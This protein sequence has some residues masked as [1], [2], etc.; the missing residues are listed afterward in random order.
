[1]LTQPAGHRRRLILQRLILPSEILPCYEDGLRGYVVL[2]ALAA[3][4]CEAHEPAALRDESSTAKTQ[5]S[6]TS[7][8][9]LHQ[10][11]R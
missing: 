2:E 5:N 9:G 7:A 3:A 10:S 6:L 8:L 4:V 11:V 1:M